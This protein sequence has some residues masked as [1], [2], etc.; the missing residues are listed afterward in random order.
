LNG[1]P[2]QPVYVNQNAAR[3]VTTTL[4][5][6]AGHAGLTRTP[7]PVSQQRHPSVANPGILS[8]I[9]LRAHFGVE[10]V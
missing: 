1:R 5:L 8:T 9:Y 2:W 7:L 3:L 10:I 6:P 4:A